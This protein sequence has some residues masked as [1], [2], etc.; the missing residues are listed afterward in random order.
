MIIIKIS[1]EKEPM[2]GLKIMYFRE[3]IHNYFHNRDERSF[4]SS[5][6]FSFF[7][8]S[9]ISS[10]LLTASLGAIFSH[11]MISQTQESNQQLLA[12][13]NYAIDK[14]QTDAN[15]LKISLLSNNSITAFLSLSDPD[16]TIPVLASQE[17]QRQLVTLPYV[18]SIYLYNPILDIVY[19]SDTGYQLDFEAA[20]DMEM[21]R[22]LEDEEFISSY[23]FTPVPMDRN[24]ETG[25]A[26][27][28]TYFIFGQ[29]RSSFSRCSAIIINVNM[30]I[31]TDSI[32]SMKNLSY[33]TASSFLLL[34]QDGG[35]LTGVVNTEIEK[36]AEWI[37]DALG[38]IPD[39]I[40]KSFYTGFGGNTYLV[41]GTDQ[42]GYGWHLLSF[43][44]TKA[45]FG[46]FLPLSLICLFIFTC[47]L[48]LTYFICRYLAKRLNQP[49]ESLTSLAKGTKPKGF[50]S[51]K[52]KEFR[53]ITDTLTTLHNS[54]RQLRTLQQ[55]TK[56][57]LLQSTLNDLVSD[58][59]L[60]PKE[61]LSEELE[62][63]DLGYLEKDRLCMALIKI[64]R[65]QTV[66][67]DHNPDEMWAIRF[68]VV[69][70]TEELASNSFRCNACSRDDD[71]FVLLIACPHS[72]DQMEFENTL[73][74]LF[75]KIQEN[76]SKYLHFTVTIA[77][78]TLFQGTGKLPAVY[79][80]TEYLLHLKMRCGHEAILDPYQIESISAESFEL[81]HKLSSQ[82]ISQLISG[83]LDSAVSSYQELS[84]GLFDCDYDE[85]MSTMI[86]LTHSIYERL[87][88]KYPM[89]KDP[90]TGAMKR[91]LDQL[92]QSET[93]EDVENLFTT[94]FQD[95]CSQVERLKANPEQQN[96]A[97]ISKRIVEIIREQYPDPSLCLTS[98]ADEIGLSANYTGHI[99]KQ[100]T[101]KSVA[102][103]LLDVRMEKVAEYLQNTSYSLNTILEKVGMEKNN[104]FYTRF[105]NYFGMP[106]GEYRQKF[107]QKEL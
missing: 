51:F 101:Q 6:L 67:Q 28:L 73:I 1:S 9:I 54:N 102:Q 19:C 40:P 79:K 88:E 68:S 86:L 41:T 48:I 85:I 22:Y 38:Q 72:A 83:K 64:D 18:D 53:L 62:Y 104:Y 96:S 46:D 14:V 55:K 17:I 36:P 97:V 91:L 25:T 20:S 44:S 98:I 100:Y 8:L 95:I 61:R 4:Y 84:K 13:T 92:A 81:S 23:G 27:T 107:C 63:L 43:V 15:R 59:P 2:K 56:Y 30:D 99:F 87:S 37:P 47:V 77:Y 60:T 49:L 52:S 74:N 21:I 5:L 78:S 12:R 93:K 39:V 24:P 50:Q 69:N 11:A 32:S 75:G 42:N 80:N 34:D 45:I 66:L 35:L 33:E 31:F 103:Y 71:K 90:L 57:S 76:I 65:Y 106:L 3:K 89:L 70:I 82:L 7:I 10:V 29:D 58:H 105:K 94:F 16:S 26:S